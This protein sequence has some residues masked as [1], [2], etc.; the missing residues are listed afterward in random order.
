MIDALIAGRIYGKPAQRATGSGKPFATAKLRAAT[1]EGD[2]HFVNVIAFASGA[3]TA[4]LALSDGDSVAIAGELSPKVWT[5][6]EGAARPSLDLVA[7]QVLSEYHVTR[8]RQAMSE[9][10]AA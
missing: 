5:D 7:H 6:K 8:K 2:I 3:V 10:A 1:R 4:L 9:D